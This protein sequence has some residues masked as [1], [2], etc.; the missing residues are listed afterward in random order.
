VREASFPATFDRSVAL[1]P[2]NKGVAFLTPA[3]PLVRAVLQRV[4]TRLWESGARD[5]VAVR[6]VAGQ[7]DPGYL[8]TFTARVQG[9]DGSLL[10]EPLLP[11][12]VAV[13]GAVSRDP[14]EDEG[15][16]HAP[17]S[18]GDGSAWAR[19]HLEEGF[20]RAVEVATAEAQ[21]RL[22]DRAAALAQELQA[23]VARLEA[24]LDRWRA[25]EQAEAYRRFQQA[26]SDGAAQL[27]LFVDDPDA[28]ALATL[29]QVLAAIEET[30]ADRARQLARAHRVG[31]VGGPDV[32]GC[33]LV[34]PE[35]LTGGER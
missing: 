7:H 26:G 12:W 33:L 16:F 10:E 21:R 6:V 35:A 4:R 13:D 32:V 19:G 28:G 3:H 34:V 18:V 30:F 11:V 25:A 14:I 17:R 31:Q 2:A 9:E 29:D 24:D 1:D 23:Q 22:D 8:V 27:G 15:C 5:R 20:D